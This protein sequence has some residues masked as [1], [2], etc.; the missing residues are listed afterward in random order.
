MTIYGISGLGAD[1]RVF[2]QLTL[3]LPV[4]PIR[5]IPPNRS[6]SLYHYALRLAKKAEDKDCILIGV[7]FGGVVAIEMSKIIKPRLTVLIS[8]AATSRELPWVYRL[9]G[10]VGILTLM[11]AFLFHPPPCLMY[12]LFG[13]KN[14]MLLREILEDTD[15]SFAKW[16][17]IQLTHWSNRERLPRV[18][19]IHGTQDRLIPYRRG[20]T[21]VPIQGGQHFMV[22]D[23]AQE[24]SR[25]IDKAF[26]QAG[27]M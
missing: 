7:S 4:V 6:E 27:L 15:R 5:W 25:A 12:G 24:V 16:A 10:S 19:K 1:E 23:R 8:S 2:Q 22:V 14:K 18:V 20:R 21:T 26:R 17:I 13:A 3:S 11:P 9:V